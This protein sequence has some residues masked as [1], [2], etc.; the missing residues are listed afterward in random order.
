MRK[1]D[2]VIDL[3]LEKAGVRLAYLLDANLMPRAAG[4]KPDPKAQTAVSRGNPDAKVWVNTKSE[5]YQCP[6]TRWY[7]KTKEPAGPKLS[8]GPRWRI[9]NES[10]YR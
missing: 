3:E 7:G 4:Q 6:G 10:S 9:P 8:D 1:A 5:A 2:P